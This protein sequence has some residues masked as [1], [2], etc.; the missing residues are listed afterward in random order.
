MAIAANR[1]WHFPPFFWSVQAAATP[2][3]SPRAD[4]AQRGTNTLQQIFRDH[5]GHFAADYDARYAKELGNFRIERITR[6]A[7]RFLS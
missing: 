3:V 5:F 1:Y 7:T 6:V 4:Y 2:S